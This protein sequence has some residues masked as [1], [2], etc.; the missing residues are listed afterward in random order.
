MAEYTRLAAQ[1]GKRCNWKPRF[2]ARVLVAPGHTGSTD[3]AMLQLPMC[4]GGTC[5]RTCFAHASSRVVQ[6]HSFLSSFLVVMQPAEIFS[7]V[8]RSHSLLPL[9]ASIM[10]PGL[11]FDISWSA[12]IMLPCVLVYPSWSAGVYT[13]LHKCNLLC[14]FVQHVC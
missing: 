3:D 9:F 10:V 12:S 4:M 1:R 5:T 7:W 11:L 6:S 2:A 14:C 8:A 13:L